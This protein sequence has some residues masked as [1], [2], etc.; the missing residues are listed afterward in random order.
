MSEKV[1]ESFI[2][3]DKAVIYC[4][5][6]THAFLKDQQKKTRSIFYGAD[7][8]EIFLFLMSLGV[9]EN[10]KIKL[11]ND[12]YFLTR[13]LTE[14][15]VWLLNAVAIKLNED[16][17]ILNNP[18]EIVKIAEEYANGGFNFF[19]KVISTPGDYSKKLHV[20]LK[21]KL[22]PKMGDENNGDN[23]SSKNKIRYFIEQGESQYIEFKPSVKWN[24]KL[25]Q[26]DKDA[27]EIIAK[28][29]AGFLNTKGGT[30][31]IGVADD[32]TLLG[33]KKDFDTFSNKEGKNQDTHQQHLINLFGTK[34]GLTTISKYIIITYEKEDDELVCLVSVKA[35]KS[36]VYLYDDKFY[37]RV[38]NTT[39]EPL[40]TK[41]AHDYINEHFNSHK[42]AD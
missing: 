25:K 31:L 18:K 34:L 36:P 38:G 35:S 9:K 30:L 12:K 27:G 21:E 29:V 26:P 42:D 33:L 7:F 37:I 11:S 28:S 3:I 19:K 16:L 2:G 23:P 41:E 4:E 17:N 39:R 22:D 14:A 24:Y 5:K 20:E 10:K 6:D 15:D 1:A 32:G 13:N 40:N 8:K